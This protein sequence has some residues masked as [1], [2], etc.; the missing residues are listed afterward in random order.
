MGHVDARHRVV[1]EEQ[2]AA[3]RRGG[4]E[5][6]AQAQRRGRAAMAAGV[7]QEGVFHGAL[8]NSAAF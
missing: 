8:H 4:L 1:G 7:N 3:A 2:D 6:P 5:G